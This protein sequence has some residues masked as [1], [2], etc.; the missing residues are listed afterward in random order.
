MKL[1][2]LLCSAFKTLS[3]VTVLSY[4]SISTLRYSV[5]PNAKLRVKFS[6]VKLAAHDSYTTR[7]GQFLSHYFIAGHGYVV[8]TLT[9]WKIEVRLRYVIGDGDVR[10]QKI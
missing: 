3:R 6:S 7:Y 2:V 10:I 4:L 8:S 5:N 1:G 9:V